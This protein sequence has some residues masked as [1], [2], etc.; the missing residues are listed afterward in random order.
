LGLDPGNVSAGLSSGIRTMKTSKDAMLERTRSEGAD[1]G[2]SILAA[3]TGPKRFV[4]ET[5][6]AVQRVAEW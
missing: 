6:I 4:A 1:D 5:A 3:V 2:W